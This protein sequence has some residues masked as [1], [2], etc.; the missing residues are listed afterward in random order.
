MIAPRVQ[1]AKK[2]M[3]KKQSTR[4][5][6]SLVLP[7]KK[8][9]VAFQRRRVPDHHPRQPLVLADSSLSALSSVSRSSR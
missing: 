6:P 4:S 8:W 2:F 1:D 3:P 5:L 7:I 9:S